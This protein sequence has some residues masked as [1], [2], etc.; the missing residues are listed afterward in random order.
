MPQPHVQAMRWAMKLRQISVMRKLQYDGRYS[1]GNASFF[2]TVFCELNGHHDPS[3][4]KTGSF[5][6]KNNGR[7]E[8]IRYTASTSG[9]PSASPW[10][11][12]GVMVPCCNDG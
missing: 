3:L 8:V 2:Q 1:N 5:F 11:I 9:S 4:R 10:M 7:L 12:T 6:S